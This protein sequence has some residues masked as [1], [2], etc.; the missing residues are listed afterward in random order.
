MSEVLTR[1]DPWLK[2]GG[3]AALVLREWLVPVEGTDG[4]VFPPTYPPSEDRTFKG[5]YNI[6]EFPDGTNVCLLDSV[7]SQANRI[8]PLFAKEP[9]SE[10]VPQVV[11]Q[12][13]RNKRVS[14][15]EVGHRAA[16]AIVR[17]SSLQQEI[18]NAFEALAAGDAAPLA[19]LAPTSLVFGVWDSRDTQVKAP[20]LLASVIRAY[21][22]RRLTRSAQYI[23]ALDYV[24]EGLIPNPADKKTRDLHSERGFLHVP[25]TGTHGGVMALGGIRRDATLHLAALRF[26]ASKSEEETLDLRRYVLGLA[27][28]AFTC[29]TPSFLRQ[30]CNL[31]RDED[32]PVETFVVEHNGMRAPFEIT[33]G[34][35][36]EFAR[37]A[38]K[39]FDV[40][41]PRTVQFEVERAKRDLEAG[42]ASTVKKSKNTEEIGGR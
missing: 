33:H 35:A 41:P 7:G 20:R 13:G 39:K 23:P 28:T 21:N 26:L 11:I 36:L 24:K 25:A 18:H 42:P 12:A 27:L 30:G 29:T 6:D 32:R 17:C 38:A 31:V 8:E 2:D 19:R 34:Q 9:Y 16:D 10:L 22:V 4:V 3:P 37:E 40:P 14:L 15:L 1:F 5:G